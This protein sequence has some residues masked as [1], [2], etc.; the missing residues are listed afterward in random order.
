MLPR[1]L[2]S[3]PRFASPQDSTVALNPTGDTFLNIDSSN[4]KYRQSLHL[5]TWPNDT[6]TNAMVIQ[7]DLSSVPAGSAI[8]SATLNLFCEAAPHVKPV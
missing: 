4:Y 6:I 7:F 5:Y 1:G 8:S 3:G 2:G